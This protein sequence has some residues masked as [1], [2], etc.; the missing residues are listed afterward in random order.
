MLRVA[1]FDADAGHPG[2]ADAMRRPAIAM[3]Y[4]VVL[5]IHLLCAFVFVGTVF[6]EVLVLHA[7]RR[8]VPRDAFAQV[9]RGIGERAR[10]LMPWVLLLLYGAGIAL[11]WHYRAA[12]AHP[13][14]SP[15][16]TMLTLKIVLA[17]SVFLHFLH[18]M[19]LRRTRR[20][21]GARSR[22]L[23]LSV[24]VHVVAIVLLA[25]GLFHVTW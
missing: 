4:Y 14:G 19:R 25:K 5:V 18:A 22:R 13:F 24:F 6:F 7:V 12:L 1:G 17:T 16:A 15:F 20:L 11:A 9:E 2:R 8:H 10:R 3:P 23:H 21:T